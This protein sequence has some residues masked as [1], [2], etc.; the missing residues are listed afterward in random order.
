MMPQVT[1]HKQQNNGAA[2]TPDNI[3]PSSIS[4]H[5]KSFLCWL[6]NVSL[7]HFLLLCAA[8]CGTPALLVKVEAAAELEVQGVLVSAVTKDWP[9]SGSVHSYL[10]IRQFCC[11]VFVGPVLR[12]ENKR[13]RQHSAFQ[14]RLAQCSQVTKWTNFQSKNGLSQQKVSVSEG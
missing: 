3:L 8:D 10:A 13:R 14:H 12:P 9:S 6:W 5:E 4:K 11:C 2:G 7:F 1:N